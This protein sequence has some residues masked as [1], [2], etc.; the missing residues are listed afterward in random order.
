[1]Q[2]PEHI[3][4]NIIYSCYRGTYFTNVFWRT[5]RTMANIP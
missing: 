3:R 2:C 5:S 1:V 4:N